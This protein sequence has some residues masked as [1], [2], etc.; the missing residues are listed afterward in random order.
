M[1]GAMPS[2]AVGAPVG[3]LHAE[4]G[5]EDL[6]F[7]C[8]QKT[9]RV[10]ATYQVDA[11]R[12]A[13]VTLDFILPV[14]VRVS[15][16]MGT[17]V[18]PVSFT[19]A[20]SGLEEFRRHLDLD[21]YEFSI[22]PPAPDLYKASATVDFV[23]GRNQVTFEYDQSLAAIETDYGYFHAGRMGAQALVCSLAPQ[24]MV[25]RQGLPDRSVDRDRP[26]AAVMVEAYLR[27]SRHRELS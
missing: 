16:R 9:C 2:S 19:S 26:R 8:H 18:V 6:A 22:L 12:A 13:R 27:P 20:A 24:G 1:E 10:T 3:D 4:V 7:R 14:N 25:S 23:A 17:S 11:D 5:H 15:A 21:Y